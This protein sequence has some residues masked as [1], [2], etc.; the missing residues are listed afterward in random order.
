[1]R[2]DVAFRLPSQ[3]LDQ[4]GVASLAG[5]IEHRRLSSLP[6]FPKALH[7]QMGSVE[8]KS[9]PIQQRRLHPRG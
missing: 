2:T 8:L 3:A 6:C 7:G 5:N 1:M 9:S 4:A